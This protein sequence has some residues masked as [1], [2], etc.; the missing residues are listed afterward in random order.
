MKKIWRIL[1]VCLILTIV[2][3]MVIF[4]FPVKRNTYFTNQDRTEAFVFDKKDF[5]VIIVGSSLSGAFEEINPFSKSY[6]NLFLPFT[7]SCTGVDI[8]RR[9][10]K[11]PKHLFVEINHIDR[12]TDTV[13]I[14][15]VFEDGLYPFKYHVPML[16]TKNKLLTNFIALIKKPSSRTNRQK[17]P[18]ALYGKLLK[19]AQ[20]EWAEY[21]D[22][23]KFDQ[24][25][26][27]LSQS[28]ALFT[29]KG[30]KVY[31]FEM[32]IDS[33]I[34][35]SVLM[36]FQRER[37]KALAKQNN[38]VFIPADTSRTYQTGDGVHLL[39]A[40]R[41]AYVKYFKDQIKKFSI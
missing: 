33:S 6:F 16:Q 39:Q 4:W 32:P 18:A 14:K 30:C 31:F 23:K 36:K 40:D 38:Y 5:N 17:P 8:I 15:D 9:S 20:K 29:N 12:G 41:N 34:R 11:I 37:I 19:S 25:I 24:Q 26:N 3:N 7:G 13:L 2:Y 21:P 1:L 35:N 22:K 28:L 10:G 27:Q